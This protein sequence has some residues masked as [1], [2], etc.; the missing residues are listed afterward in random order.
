M[1]RWKFEIVE[2]GQVVAEGDAPDRD[3]ALT[4][5]AHLIEPARH[6]LIRDYMAL[7]G[8]RKATWSKLKRWGWQ[9][10]QIS[11]REVRT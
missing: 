11:I 6:L 4:E 1:A 7:D 2:N 10:V 8:N 5:A 3:S 9:C